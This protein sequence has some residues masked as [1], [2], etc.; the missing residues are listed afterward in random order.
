VVSIPQ[1]TQSH[2]MLANLNHNTMYIFSP[3]LLFVFLN[4][5]IIPFAPE[6]GSLQMVKIET[7]S[8]KIYKG[9]LIIYEELFESTQNEKD[10]IKSF[11]FKDSLENYLRYAR[12]LELYT[13]LLSSP[14]VYR[15]LIL[16]L[17]NPI[18]IKLDDINFIERKIGK[19]NGFSNGWG[20]LN[21]ITTKEL[22]LLKLQPY[23]EYYYDGAGTYPIFI[24][25]ST[26]N[27]KFKLISLYNKYQKLNDLEQIRFKKRVLSDSIVILH[28]T[29]D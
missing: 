29:G 27:T 14:T 4:S 2:K 5:E 25:Y 9:Y 23:S 15:G 13:D 22:N 18:E 12:K 1:R 8:N 20:E 16:S 24:S 28:Y 11:S 19:Y 10:C 26:R 21:V 7:C 17:K 6:E 3:L